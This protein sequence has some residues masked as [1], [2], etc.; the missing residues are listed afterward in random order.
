MLSTRDEITTAL[1]AYCSYISAQN[2]QALEFYVPL[3]INTRPPEDDIDEDEIPQMR[4]NS[5]STLL[6]ASNHVIQRV[7]DG[8]PGLISAPEEVLTRYD[9]LVPW[10]GLDGVFRFQESGPA[11][12]DRRE[13][14]RA[15]YFDS[16]ERALKEKCLEEVRG[17]IAIPEE[18]RILAEMGV[19]G[20]YGPGLGSYK[21]KHQ[22]IFWVGPGEKP[23][24]YI[25]RVQTAA[26]LASDT[27]LETSGWV[28]GG[29]WKTG[30]GEGAVC[31]AL[32]CRR[33]DEEEFAWRYIVSLEGDQPMFE[34]L[35]ELL[36]WYKGFR[37]QK[38]EDIRAYFSEEQVFDEI[39]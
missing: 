23:E 39:W 5:L 15:E 2:R 18:L 8:E 32:Y 10:L 6:S 30:E 28:I 1:D 3:I 16:I 14:C 31:Y 27:G 11:F 24:Y 12:H 35:P 21:T 13:V 37:E 22:A 33:D 29:G 20:L 26:K 25:A 34:T 7:R 38:I 4:L 19:D 36:G 17:T 9:E